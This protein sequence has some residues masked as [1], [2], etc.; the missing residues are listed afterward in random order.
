MLD[1]I[2][3]VAKRRKLVLKL[4]GK[5]LEKKGKTFSWRCNSFPNCWWSKGSPSGQT[6]T[7]LLPVSVVRK[8]S[9]NRFFTPGGLR[10]DFTP[11]T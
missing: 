6:M 11:N 10:G 8:N 2:A 4:K 3:A 9:T 7:F 1:K 5:S